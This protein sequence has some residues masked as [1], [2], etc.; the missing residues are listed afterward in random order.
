MNKKSEASQLV[1]DFYVIINTQFGTNAKV[2][3]SDNGAE[4]TS[5]P[6]RKFYREK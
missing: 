5:N 6:M 4:F 3:R 1:M 2:I